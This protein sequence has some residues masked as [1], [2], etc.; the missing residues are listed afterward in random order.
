MANSENGIQLDLGIDVLAPINK[1]QSEADPRAFKR[2]LDDLPMANTGAATQNLFNRLRTMNAL[3]IP[4]EKRFE[5]MEMLRPYIHQVSAGLQKQYGEKRLPL[6][7]KVRRIFDLN[8][9][10]LVNMATA[11]KIIVHNHANARSKASKKTVT[12]AIARAIR[13]LALSLI[14]SYLVYAPEAEMTWHSL[15]TL[16]RYAHKLDLLNTRITIDDDQKKAETSISNEYMQILV[17][18]AIDPYHLPHGEV[19]RIYAEISGRIGL[20]KLDLIKPN[21][22]QAGIFLVRLNSD[23]PPVHVSSCIAKPDGFSLY[24]DTNPLTQ[25]ISEE[26][27]RS[28]KKSF[29]SFRKKALNGDE[30][31]LTSVLVGLGVTPQREHKRT[32]SNSRVAVITGLSQIHQTLL[33]ETQPEMANSSPCPKPNF[34]TREIQ[35]LSDKTFNQRDIWK[36]TPKPGKPDPQNEFN[37]L[38]PNQSEHN[39]LNT[40]TPNQWQLSNISAGGYCV[41]T[42]PGDQGKAHVGELITIRETHKYNGSWQTGVVRWIRQEKNGSIAL[43]VKILY[44]GGHPVYAKVRN[45]NG[46]YSAPERAIL[47]PAL[48]SLNKPASILALGQPFETGKQV[49]V[50]NR[51]KLAA[52]VLTRM[53]TGTP[54]YCQYEYVCLNDSDKH[55]LSEKLD[56]ESLSDFLGSL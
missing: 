43:G 52:I 53:I 38:Y 25:A 15:H 18:A 28:H 13:Y 9:E 40:M 33:S 5:M 21:T 48:V 20:A 1:D 54:F 10:L 31:T 34:E 19:T 47:L 45:E 6:S 56:E 17:A 42:E 23:H 7:E 55:L 12:C 2:W 4:C 39:R 27:E 36:F 37:L 11:Y 46:V 51:N 14:E 22:Q 41:I 44:A 26:I 32:E 8:R 35:S 24:L 16:Y 29:F 3:D 50:R 30:N 49:Q